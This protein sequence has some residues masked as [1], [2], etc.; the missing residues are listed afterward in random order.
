MI[1]EFSPNCWN[2]N[3]KALRLPLFHSL[4][5]STHDLHTQL[6][7]HDLLFLF[8]RHPKVQKIGTYDK[9]RNGFPRFCKSILAAYVAQMLRIVGAKPP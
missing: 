4:K 2:S 9:I 8:Q 1:F 6:G 7:A 3:L 5:Y